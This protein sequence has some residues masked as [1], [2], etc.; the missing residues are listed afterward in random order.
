MEKP[1]EAYFG[2]WITLKRD[3]F[4]IEETKA[5]PDGTLFA[6]CILREDNSSGVNGIIRFIQEPGQKMRAFG[7]IS[8]LTPGPHGFHVH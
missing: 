1:E 3:L 5:H 2:D 4:G 6:V 7:D 8:G